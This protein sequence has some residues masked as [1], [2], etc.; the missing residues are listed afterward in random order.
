MD[1]TKKPIDDAMAKGARAGDEKLQVLQITY[2][3]VNYNLLSWRIRRNR[4]MVKGLV[5]NKMEGSKKLNGLKA[6][7]A[8]WDAILQASQR[9][10]LPN[11]K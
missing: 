1:V 3:Y 10:S 4:V 7:V 11:L 5:N 9:Y 6:E 2:T 8:L